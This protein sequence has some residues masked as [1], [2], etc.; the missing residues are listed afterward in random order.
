MLPWDVVGEKLA[1]LLRFLASAAQALVAE[2]R[3]HAASL[4][5]ALATLAVA[6]PAAAAKRPA[7][8]ADGES[9]I[10]NRVVGGEQH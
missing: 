8:L 4:L 2:L 3:E 1:E 7:D 5:A 6:L 10:P 9:L